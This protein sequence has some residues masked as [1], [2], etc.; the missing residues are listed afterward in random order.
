M[1]NAN[2][3]EKKVR[4][5]GIDKK[6]ASDSLGKY[7]VTYLT[8]SVEERRAIRK[9]IHA[10][11]Q[12]CTMNSD[13]VNQSEMMGAARCKTLHNIRRADEPFKAKIL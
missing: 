3:F 5:C 8:L 2:N 1:S 13:N 11:H 6:K 10:Y 4:H 7:L 9:I 12:S